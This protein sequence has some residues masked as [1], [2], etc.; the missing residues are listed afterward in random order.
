[1]HGQKIQKITGKAPMVKGL[2]SPGT[3]VTATRTM[4]MPMK[5]QALI[6]RRY[7]APEKTDQSD[8]WTVPDDRKVN[9]WDLNE[10]DPTDEGTMGT[11]PGATI[12]CE[13]GDKVIVHFR[14]LDKRTFQDLKETSLSLAKFPEPEFEPVEDLAQPPIPLPVTERTHSLH[15]HGIVFDRK[16]DGAYPLS[17][18]DPDQPVGAEEALWKFIGVTTHKKGDRVPPGGTFTYTWD[19][20]GFAT[21]AGVWI[22]HDH[23]IC[24]VENVLL[25]AIGFLVI[26]NPADPDDVIDQD[27]PGG[28]FN[29]SPVRPMDSCF[30]FPSPL[31]ILPY[32]LEGLIEASSGV[33]DGGSMHET[34]YQTES[35][36][37]APRL[38]RGDFVFEMDRSLKT[39][40]GLCLSLYRSPPE[41]AQYLQIFHELPGIGMSINGRRFLG[42]TPT[43]VGGLETKMRF[44]L[45][46]MNNSTFHTFHL[47]GHRWIIPGP[48]GTSA[49]AIENS[50]QTQAVTQF[51][52]TKIF[53]PANTFSFTINQGSAMGAF[54]PADPTRAP[55]VGEWHMHCHVLGHMMPGGMMGSL[56]VIRGGEPAFQLPRGVP[57]PTTEE[58]PEHTIRTVSDKFVPDFLEV[59]SG[60]IVT[61]DFAE[62]DHSVT[63][64]STTGSASAIE[65]NGGDNSKD[66]EGIAIPEGQKRTVTVTGSPGDEISYICGI[67]RRSMSGKIR[68]GKST[69]GDHH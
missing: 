4:F 11:I 27:L 22:Y 59:P 50:P 69:N 42:N 15:P 62:I 49:G 24:D 44:G 28:D 65:I 6:L 56:L 13:V 48:V 29:G 14:N 53:G 63:T 41:K 23:S 46:A 34:D 60:T 47:H 39:I 51:E 16:H 20:L 2:R 21:T 19:T 26:H 1:M 18:P 30:P 64:N 58:V 37:Q 52:D 17:P 9:P 7:K 66:D 67:H 45:A 31:P 32:D 40:T 61:F 57:C 68:I 10:P 54:F 55:G 25:G 33:H 38:Q 35:R 43:M 12:E 5:G 8:A 36:E 3:G